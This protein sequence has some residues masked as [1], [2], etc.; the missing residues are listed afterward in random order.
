[1]LHVKK[2]PGVQK[3][4]TSILI[5]IQDKINYTINRGKKKVLM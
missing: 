1:M 4:H 5:L 3:K 2:D